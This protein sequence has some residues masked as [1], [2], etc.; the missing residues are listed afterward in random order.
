MPGRRAPV[1]LGISIS[2]SMVLVA[3]SSAL[4]KRVTD[5]LKSLSGQ[6]LHRG[7]HRHAVGDERHF[8]LRHE[9]L[10]AQPAVIHQRHHGGAL[11]GRAGSGG[12]DE[13]AGVHESRRDHAGKGR[14]QPG[15][16]QQCPG[17]LEF[18]LRDFP[19]AAQ[20]VH[21]LRHDQVRRLLAGLRPCAR[22]WCGPPPSRPGIESRRPAIP[23]LR[24]R[25]ATGPP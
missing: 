25:P 21:R 6:F 17:A 18:G 3:S 12:G 24:S 16:L 11:R 22:S 7:L 15:I 9:D 20:V 2:V 10:D 5:P 8:R 19:L 4:A 23:A 14:G 1:G 13:R